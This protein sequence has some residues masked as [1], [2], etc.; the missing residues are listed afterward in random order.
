[1]ENRDLTR[2]VVAIGRL[3]LLL[4]N[5]RDDCVYD[6]CS[7]KSRDYLSIIADVKHLVD[8]LDND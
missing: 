7:F 2:A 1:M 8:E 6:S 5:E 3:A 4:A